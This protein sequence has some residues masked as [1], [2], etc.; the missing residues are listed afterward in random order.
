MVGGRS[1]AHQL[2]GLLSGSIV[3]KTQPFMAPPPP[4]SRAVPHGASSCPCPHR[5]LWSREHLGE[6]QLT[7][8]ASPLLR[9]MLHTFTTRPC[10]A[11]AYL[12][13]GTHLHSSSSCSHVNSPP[14][15]T[16]QAR[17]SMNPPHYPRAVTGD[18]PHSPSLQQATCR[19]MVAEG[20]HAESS[21]CHRSDAEHLTPGPCCTRPH[22]AA[23]G[24]IADKAA[25]SEGRWNS[26]WQSTRSTA[27]TC[28]A[29]RPSWLPEGVRAGR[30]DQS[31]PV[32]EASS[33]RNGA[34]A[35]KRGLS[36]STDLCSDDEPVVQSSFRRGSL[37]GGGAPQRACSSH[38]GETP[39]TVEEQMVSLVGMSG[40]A[41]REAVPK[42]GTFGSTR[43]QS[44]VC[45]PPVVARTAC[46]MAFAMVA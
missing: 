10:P 42:T 6:R 25:A 37:W 41:V 13:R 30:C 35:P 24:G 34:V 40:A 18:A 26:R 14:C 21:S 16:V 5:H 3:Q 23:L 15:V 32:T 28:R 2:L 1:N 36:L 12:K 44:T 43:A 33:P 8:A 4:L 29:G 9:T 46:A 7:R 20:P 45:R 22:S 31:R 11:N 27:E 19:E 39:P 17:Q 38:I